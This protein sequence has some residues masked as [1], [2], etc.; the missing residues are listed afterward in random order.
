ML[1]T[2]IEPARIAAKTGYL[3]IEDYAMVGDLYT[4]ALVGK[5]GSID[6]G[7]RPDF[8]S[9]S[10]FGALLDAGKGG[11]FRLAPAAQDGVSTKQMYFPESNILITRFLCHH[12]VGEITDFM[13]VKQAGDQGP[14][15]HL[16]RAVHMVRGALTFAIRCR[17]A[18]NYARDP[19]ELRLEERGAVFTGPALTLA[20]SSS[21]S[22]NDDGC[23][24]AQAVFTLIEDQSAYFFLDSSPDR[25]LRPHPVSRDMY[26]DQFAETRRYWRRWLSQCHYQGRWRE[27]VL[28]RQARSSLRRDEPS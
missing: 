5:N 6:S 18:F 16:V 11:H 14:E 1:R 13:P 26:E 2:E 20:L 3:P 28:L 9:P 15:H 22:L 25:H 10:V 4:V 21:V 23:G 12:G 7:C 27:P 19:H 24:G 17:P 8:D